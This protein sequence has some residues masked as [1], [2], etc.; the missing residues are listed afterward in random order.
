MNQFIKKLILALL[1][2]VAVYGAFVIWTGVEKVSVALERFE[3]WTFGLALGLSS[4]NYLLRFAKWEYYLSVLGIRGV[5]KLDSLLIFLSGFVLTVTPG[6][7]G[8]V[9][10]SALLDETY[11]VDAARTAPIVIAERLTDV[12]GVIGLILIGSLGFEGG[13][14]W[15]LAGT[16]CVFVGIALIHWPTPALRLFQWIE[17]R[18]PRGEKLAPRLRL[19][20]DSLRTVAHARTLLIPSLLSLLGWALEGVALGALVHGT[21]ETIALPVALFF[22]ATSTLAG[23]IVPTPGGLGVAETSLESQ[24]VTVGHLSAGAATLSMLLIRFATLWWAVVV[25][26]VALGLLKLRFPTLLSGAQQ[27][28]KS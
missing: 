16:L 2:G 13:V 19:A 26:F 27:E 24:L 25:G 5:R 4:L 17:T 6:K 3:F 21:G 11:S 7:I 14:G 22:Y 12:I 20:F 23:A 18:G 8:E 1:L 15:A 10:K 9:F 28:P